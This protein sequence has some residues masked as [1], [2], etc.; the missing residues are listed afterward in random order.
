MMSRSILPWRNP[1]LV[2]QVISHKFM[3][4]LVPLMMIVAFLASLAAV[5]WPP[6]VDRAGWLYLAVPYNYIFFGLEVLVYILAFLGGI[7]KG[8]GLLGKLLYLPAFLVNSNLSAILGLY[9][10]FTGKQTSL[11]RRVRRRGETS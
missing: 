10:F 8:R 1:V 5:V 9:S 11:W 3:R 7:F 2:W 4:P 6:Q